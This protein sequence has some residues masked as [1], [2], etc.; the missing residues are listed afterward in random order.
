MKPLELLLLH[1]WW[2]ESALIRLKESWTQALRSWPSQ[3]DRLAPVEL[4]LAMPAKPSVARATISH[5]QG[6]VCVCA[7]MKHGESENWRSATYVDVSESHREKSQL[8]EV[9]SQIFP[10]LKR[11]K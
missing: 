7:P 11:P 1:R 5:Q 9:L 2:I 6:P 3:A 8:A 10:V 4:C